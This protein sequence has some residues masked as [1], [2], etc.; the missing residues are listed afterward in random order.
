MRT[1]FHILLLLLLAIVFAGC[2]GGDTDESNDDADLGT[3][4]STENDPDL[5][6]TGPPIDQTPV[7]ETLYLDGSG[8]VADLPSE[9]SMPMAGSYF[10]CFVTRPCSFLAFKSEPTD[11]PVAIGPG[12]ITVTYWL[13]TDAVVPSAGA[14]DHGVWVGSTY[15]MA[16]NS[17]QT[18]NDVIVAGTPLKVEFTL[19]FGTKAPVFVPAGESVQIYLISGLVHEQAGTL[20]LLYGG[21]TPSGITYTRHNL[22]EDPLANISAARPVG[23]SGA[24]AGPGFPTS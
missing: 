15:A 24:L 4:G 19:E 20:E 13:A 12:P 16:L 6:T 1:P 7:E 8:L 23:F 14:F 10:S 9:G 3:D 22:T 11:V 18:N 2:T 17:I 5:D 21:D